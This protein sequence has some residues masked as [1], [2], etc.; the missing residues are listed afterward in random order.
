[1]KSYVVTWKYIYRILSGKSR[2]QN[3]IYTAIITFK[4]YADSQQLL[5]CRLLVEH[6]FL[7]FLEFLMVVLLKS[8]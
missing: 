6:Y 8:L 7:K 4:M 2:T 1:M 5:C 3:Y